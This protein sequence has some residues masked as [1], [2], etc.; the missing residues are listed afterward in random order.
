MVDE[1]LSGIRRGLTAVEGVTEVE[2]HPDVVQTDLLDPEDR[3]RGGVPGHLHARLTR[4]VFDRDTQIGVGGSQLAHAV[5][6]QRPQI[7][8]VDLEGV[9][10]TVLSRPDL[11]VL[12]VECPHDA[13]GVV[14]QG[15]RLATHTR[16]GIGEGALTELPEVDLWSHAR[17]RKVVLVQRLL[18]LLERDA[19]REGIGHIHGR[20]TF[21]LGSPIDHLERRDSRGIS[22]RRISIDVAREVPQACAESWVLGHLS[23]I[24]IRARSTS[25]FHA[26][27]SRSRRSAGHPGA[28][29]VSP[30]IEPG[31]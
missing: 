24:L 29:E 23:S 11:Q 28:T 27:R 7:V 21:D 19:R 25:R 3:P 30:S 9:V 6:G 22:V 1:E 2:Q 16:I 4:L 20:Q 10:P 14:H 5:D 15:E 12:A 26:F 18:H 8:V 31:S 13:G 17:D